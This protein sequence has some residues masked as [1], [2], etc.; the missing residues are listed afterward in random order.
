MQ[1]SI[2]RKAR[3]DKYP[4]EIFKGTLDAKNDYKIDDP[5]LIHKKN[6]SNNL[7]A[8]RMPG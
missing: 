2:E 4:K 3:P 1:L 8:N 5:V 7:K 6:P